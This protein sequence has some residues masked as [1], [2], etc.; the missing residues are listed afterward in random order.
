MSKQWYVVHTY[1]GFE[2]KVA[3]SLRQRAKAFNMTDEIGEILIPTEN[4][5]EIR[6]GKKVVT[7]KRFCPG[8]ILVEMDM[9]DR[10]W[11]TVKETAKV[12]GFVGS[13]LRPS[14]LTDDEVARIKNQVTSAQDK[15]KM[16]HLFERGESVRI[17][18]GPFSNFN[19]VVEQVNPERNTV[20]VMVPIFGRDIPVELDFLQVEK[21]AG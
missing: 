5:V 3:E 16:K 6:G 13:G 10:S 18:D 17:V 19:G 1:S 21:F 9:N 14:P 2:K 8:Y 11:H 4:V 7:T 20:K 12:T 15:P